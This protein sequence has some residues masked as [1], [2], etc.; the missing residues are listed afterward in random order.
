MN[1][2]TNTAAAPTGETLLDIKP[3]VAIPSGW[4]WL[5]WTLAV[6]AVLALVAGLL[7]WLKHRRDHRPAPP[8]IPPHVR[9]LERLQEALRLLGQPEPFVVAVS[10]A[11]RVYLE[12]RFDFHAPERT[13]EE[14]LHELQATMLLSERQKV[15][16]AGFLESCDLVKFARYQPGETELQ[17][18]HGAA[19][20][21]VEETVPVAEPSP[22][23]AAPA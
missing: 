15:S 18:L 23:P 11:L 7:L 9:A 20:G 16:L 10:S 21:L 22:N 14:F 5:W 2:T 13:T 17:G 6:L 4:E 8:A 19:I 3:P 1:Q 12:E